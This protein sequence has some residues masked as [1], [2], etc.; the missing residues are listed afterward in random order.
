[1]NV[2]PHAY[3]CTDNTR[4][5]CMYYGLNTHI[6]ALYMP[7]LVYKL[8]VLLLRKVLKLHVN[9]RFQ[10]IEFVYF[11]SCINRDIKYCP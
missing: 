6:N 2:R 4:T 8:E 5:V 10:I 3:T 1:M 9:N 7:W 11:S